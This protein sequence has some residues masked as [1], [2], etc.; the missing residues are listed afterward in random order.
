ML[1]PSTFPYFDTETADLSFVSSFILTGDG[2][3]T[4]NLARTVA[5]QYFGSC[6]SASNW[7]NIW[8]VTFL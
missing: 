1:T 8:I 6:V 3:E 4:Y 5:R 2:N 7:S